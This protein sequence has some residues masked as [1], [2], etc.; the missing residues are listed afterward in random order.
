M[1]L[2]MMEQSSQLP[3]AKNKRKNLSKWVLFVGMNIEFCA[4]ISALANFNFRIQSDKN[5]NSDKLIAD[6][7]KFTI[8]TPFAHEQTK[9]ILAEKREGR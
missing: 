8:S 7:G 1:N 4:K 2:E 5:S 9:M 3:R 6:C